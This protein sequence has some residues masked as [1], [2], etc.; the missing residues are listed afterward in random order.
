MKANLAVAA[1]VATVAFGLTQS[2]RAQIQAGLDSAAIEQGTG[3]K[4]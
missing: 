1:T 4:G 2:T 3:L